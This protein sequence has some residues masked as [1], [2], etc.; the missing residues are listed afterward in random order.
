MSLVCVHILPQIVH[1]IQVHNLR[2]CIYLTSDF[3]HIIT[4][5]RFLAYMTSD[6]VYILP[7]IM[8]I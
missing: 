3:V 7:Q 8:F 6:I 5:L 2:F 1:I 4:D